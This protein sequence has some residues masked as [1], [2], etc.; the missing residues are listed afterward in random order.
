MRRLDQALRPP[1]SGPLQRGA[2]F[3]RAECGEKGLHRR[4]LL[5][6]RHQ[7]EIIMLFRERNETEPDRI[8]DRRNG[9]AP[10]GAVL[11]DGRGHRVVRAWLVPIAVRA[12]TGEQP[13]DQD[14]RAG[15]LV[16]V[17]HD[18]GGIS[19]RRDDSVLR[20]VAFETLVALAKH[21]ALHPSPAR[22]ELESFDEVRRIVN[23]ALVVEQMDRRQIAFA[24][25]CPASPP[26]LPTAIE[27]TVRRACASCTVTRSRPVQWLPTMTRSG[28]RTC[29]VNSVTPASDP[30][31]I[32]S[33]SASMRRKPSACAN[34]VI[35]PDPLPEG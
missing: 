23:L 26:R 31:G 13:V 15:A 9:H 12:R 32:W 5:A 30:A 20:A 29:G 24:A 33:G 34:D 14:A 28:T 27:R 17:D 16:A 7:R 10:V 1:E 4:T 6:R 2:R 35:A 22:H 25:P 8:G 21:D 19:E 11:C 3:V 18:A